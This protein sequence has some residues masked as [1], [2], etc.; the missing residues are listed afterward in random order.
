[1]TRFG[2]TTGDRQLDSANMSLKDCLK[3]YREITEIIREGGMSDEA[4]VVKKR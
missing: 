2:W 4:F 1:M 3:S